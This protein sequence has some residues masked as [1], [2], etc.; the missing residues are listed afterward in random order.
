MKSSKNVRGTTK[1]FEGHFLVTEIDP[2]TGEPLQPEK[3]TEKF[4]HHCGARVRDRLSMN[5]K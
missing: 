5:G 1:P 3:N 4:I 2:N